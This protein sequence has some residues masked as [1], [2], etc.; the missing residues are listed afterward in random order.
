MNDDDTQPSASSM[1]E[2]PK[3]KEL[4][5]ADPVQ[6]LL[7]RLQSGM[8]AGFRETNANI[9]VVSSALDVVKD[10]VHVIE[11]W[12]V[13]QDARAA[14]TSD[15]VRGLSSS[16]LEQQAKIA[17]GV[18]RADALETAIHETKELAL[19]AAATLKEQSD[20]MGL[21]KKGLK[22]VGSKEGR[23]ALSQAAIVVGVVYGILKSAGVLK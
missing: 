20:F 21:G 9:S 22:W 4:P 5:A 13:D 12:K 18:I 14:R 3:T 15:G 2:Q 11:K 8:D 19:Q 17:A 6:V 1:P 23:A 7:M 10:R 16:D